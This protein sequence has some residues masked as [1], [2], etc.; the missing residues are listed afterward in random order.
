M[1]K[2]IHAIVKGKC[3]S[4]DTELPDFKREGTNWGIVDCPSED[5]NQ[6]FDVYRYLQAGG[7]VV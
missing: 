1:S 5:C 3:P 4:C 7:L 2:T 6:W